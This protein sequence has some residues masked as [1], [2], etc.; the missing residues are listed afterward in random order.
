MTL[1]PVFTQLAGRRVLVIGGGVVAERKVH[2]L[3]TAG[4][5]VVV[6]ARAFT[7]T[8]AEQHRKG[9]IDI[10]TG[11]FESYWL[12]EAWLVVAATDDGPLN[13]HIAT[14][15]NQ[16]RLFVN[17]VDDPALSSFQV[18]S[19]VD[20]SPL[21]IAISSGGS[22]PVLA[23]RLRERFESLVD[24]SIGALSQLAQKHRK[25]IRAQRPDLRRRR[26]FYDWLLDGPVASAL[27][28]QQPQLAEQLMQRE[29][30]QVPTGVKGSVVLVGAGP[31]DP[32]LLTLKALRALNEA[33][34]ILYDRLV[35]A[36]V[37]DLARRD[38]TRIS[39]GKTPGED[40]N[41]TQAR[42]HAL[43]LQHVQN[44]QRVVRLKGGDAFVFG[45][46]GEE[47]EF[48][49]SQGISYEVV[50]GITAALACAAYAG[51][52]LTHRD[53]AQS[54]RFIT[55]HCSK[56]NDL[57]D[58][59]ALAQAKQ[60]LAF[61]MGVGQLEWLAHQLMSHGRHPHTPFALV[62][63]G[64][65]SNQRVL[66]GTLGRLASAAR[67]HAFQAPSLLLVGEVAALSQSLHWFG[68]RI[69]ASA[70]HDGSIAGCAGHEV[71]FG[72]HEDQALTYSA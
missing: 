34:V 70:N 9:E 2:L 36:E 68:V 38:A 28:R 37:L 35:S 53:H 47:L 72:E 15:C 21:V 59:P 64:S 49:A 31:G 66:H 32:G 12:D 25:S 13:Q 8:L 61:Y 69:D 27:R 51:V 7:A 17:V 48:L 29:L 10:I 20:R 55:A 65:R 54:V 71:P 6:G 62:E 42:I 52:P 67:E 18:P 5:Q 57:Q 46:G 33:D 41:A 45:R 40:H 16:R 56:D 30:A 39:V 3:V 4:A 24:H 50:P 22:A 23:R 44:G 14:L 1:F 11:G 26:E 19:I 58:W 60:T 43:M 63:N